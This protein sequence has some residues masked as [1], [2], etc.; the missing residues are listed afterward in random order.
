[1]PPLSQAPTGRDSWSSSAET[2]KPYEPALLLKRT[3][4]SGQRIDFDG[5]V[6]VV[7]DVNPGAVITCTGDIVVIGTLRGVAHAGAGGN[8]KAQVVAFRL[9]PTQLR[10]ASVISRAPDGESPHP[11]APEVALIKDGAIHIQ[12]YAPK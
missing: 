5:N 3:L 2:M 11:S 12:T 9:E 1:M 7:G 10:I 6:V 8:T 4:R